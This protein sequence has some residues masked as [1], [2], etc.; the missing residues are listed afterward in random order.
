M[1][2][3][4]HIAYQ[5]TRYRG[6]Q[7]QKETGKTVQQFVENG[8]NQVLKTKVKISACGRTDAEV[9]ASQFFFHMDIE[10]VPA[11]DLIF[12]LNK[13]WPHDISLFEIIPV[14]D[15]ANAR[16]DAIE[17]TY[18]YYIH[19][20]KNP[21]INNRSSLYENLDLDRSK[22]E[23]ALR[24]LPNYSDFRAFCKQPD[25]HK[26]TICHIKNA[27]LKA[28]NFEDKF[29]FQLTANRY[30]KGMI[31]IL[32]YR[33][34]KVGTEEMSLDEFENY[35][36]TKKASEAVQSAYPQGLYLTKVNYPYL[37]LPSRHTAP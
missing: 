13:I 28:D 19:R 36:V 4:F 9:H 25:K 22:I 30:L 29:S 11:D 27:L 2:Y 14:S 21:F 1:R 34:L 7:W 37:D 17:R 23:Q 10:D 12:V 15:K 26:T 24:I 16:F 6:W 20:S 5:G 35:L 18:E 33:L 8:L 31:R 32:V 3:F